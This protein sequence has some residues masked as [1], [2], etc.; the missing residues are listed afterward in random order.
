VA[1]VALAVAVAPVAVA[2]GDDG[3]ELREPRADQT[4][5]TTESAPSDG[6]TAADPGVEAGSASNEAE[7]LPSVSGPLELTSPAFGDGEAI[8]QRHTCRGADVSPP[9]QW[10]ETPDG[11]VELA[12]VVR[13][14]D[15]EDFLHWVIAGLPPDLGGLAEDTVPDDA[16]EAT[17]D[18]GRPGWGGPC[19]P[20]GTHEYEFRVYALA[21]PSGVGADQ[22]GVEAVAAIEALPALGSPVLNGTASAD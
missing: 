10:G 15:A 14:V 9:L 3:T 5:T 11:T 19:P 21:E 6:D 18:F 13:D 17:N 12:V 16:V 22:P 2:C 7:S 1:L 20:S 4:T 8:P